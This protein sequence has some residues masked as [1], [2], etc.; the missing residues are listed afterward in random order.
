MGHAFL[1]LKHQFLWFQLFHCQNL[2]QYVL[3]HRMQCDLVLKALQ[4]IFYQSELVFAR[5][6]KQYIYAHSI[7]QEVPYNDRLNF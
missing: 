7:Y 5:P 3:N 6:A 1:F 4:T 2:E